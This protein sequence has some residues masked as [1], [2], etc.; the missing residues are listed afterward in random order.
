MKNSYSPE[1]TEFIPKTRDLLL[2][3]F[4][5]HQW[6]NLLYSRNKPYESLLSYIKDNKETYSWKLQIKDVAKAINE[7]PEKVTKWIKQVYNDIYE[8]NQDSPELFKQPGF[9]YDFFFRSK[10]YKDAYFTLWFDV[11]VNRGDLF[12]FHFIRGKFPTSLFWVESIDHSY[13]NGHSVTSVNLVSRRPNSY[14][15]LVRDKQVFNDNINSYR[16]IQGDKF[17]YRSAL[18]QE[19]G[20]THLPEILL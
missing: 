14:L 16:M 8:L 5:E 3:L 20:L 6:L 12:E 9:C 13:A 10:Y 7:K 2:C 1:I 11:P 18:E 17:N 15:N 4:V 19:Y